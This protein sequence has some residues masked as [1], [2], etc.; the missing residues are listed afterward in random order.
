[1]GEKFGFIGKALESIEYGLKFLGSTDKTIERFFEGGFVI[2]C[3]KCNTHNLCEVE[4]FEK[5]FE[6][7]NEKGISF[8]KYGKEF[9]LFYCNKCND[10]AVRY[11]K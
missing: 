2:N 1:M 10:Y 6:N 5:V 3:P 9:D 7:L 11:K 4:S 8:E